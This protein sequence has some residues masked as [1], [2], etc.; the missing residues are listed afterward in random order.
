ML[1]GA[2]T[3]NGE[4]PRA[5]KDNRGGEELMAGVVVVQNLGHF[6]ICLSF[7]KI[8]TWFK[9]ILFRKISMYNIY[10]DNINTLGYERKQKERICT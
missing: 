3:P 10:C 4:I 1:L 5:E 6:L 7:L 8:C 2:L 9:H